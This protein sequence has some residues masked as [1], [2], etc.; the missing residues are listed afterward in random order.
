[1][2]GQ[3]VYHVDWLRSSIDSLRKMAVGLGPRSSELAQ[4]VR[5]L[6]DRLRREPLE[7][8]EIYRRRGNVSE[9]LAI[10]GF[11]AIDFAVDEQR[12]LVV[13]RYCR[14]LSGHGI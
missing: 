2:P 3:P 5:D 1:M 9:H 4:I 8:G 6:D 10:R 12:R 14:A 11:L 13:V 7:L